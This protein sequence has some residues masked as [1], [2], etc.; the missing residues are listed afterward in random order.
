M[1]ANNQLTKTFFTCLV[2]SSQFLVAFLLLSSVSTPPTVSQRPHALS[3]APNS[4]FYW[5]NRSTL[6]IE[7]KTVRHLIN[8]SALWS[9]ASLQKKKWT[10][11]MNI[12]NCDANEAQ[13]ND[14]TNN[15]NNKREKKAF[16]R[17]F[18]TLKLILWKKYKNI[19]DYEK[20]TTR[21]IIRLTTTTFPKS[22]EKHS[23]ADAQCRS[24]ELIQ[25]CDTTIWVYL[26]MFTYVSPPVRS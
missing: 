4:S 16:R 10:M 18:G 22:K 2:F 15:H 1:L 24:A 17:P 8:T 19:Y 20:Y 21:L 5:P 14:H 3:S 9:L 6:R 25:P 7:T 13:H 26:N 11:F 12:I 23:K